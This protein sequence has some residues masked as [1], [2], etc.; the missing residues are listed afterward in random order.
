[1]EIDR[2][3]A[4]LLDVTLDPLANVTV[5]AGTTL[6]LLYNPILK[7]FLYTLLKSNNDLPVNIFNLVVPPAFVG[8]LLYNQPGSELLQFLLT[9]IL[10]SPFVSSG[11]PGQ[12]AF[13]LEGLS[14]PSAD[15][16]DVIIDL[17]NL[18]PNSA[19][20]ADALNQLHPA[21][22]SAFSLAQEN[23]A[24][25]SRSLYSERADELFYTSCGCQRPTVI[26]MVCG[27]M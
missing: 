11:N 25:R 7:N 2:T 14:D 20:M 1:M 15:L 26:A 6:N 23:L 9:D 27:L 10:L 21:A 8:Q 17:A 24:I 3:N 22:F 19:A 4:D 18:S 12:V 16:A 13:Y 5:N